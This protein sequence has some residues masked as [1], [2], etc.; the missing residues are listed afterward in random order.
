ML[1]AFLTILSAHKEPEP[2]V[3]IRKLNAMVQ[4]TATPPSIS[5]DNVLTA[6]YL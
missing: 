6:S 5:T 4:D 3:S 2:T 1:N